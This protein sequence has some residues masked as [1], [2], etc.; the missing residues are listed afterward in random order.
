MELN[1]QSLKKSQSQQG[2][3]HLLIIFKNRFSYNVYSS[4][5][6]I[7][8]IL[9]HPVQDFT[10]AQVPEPEAGKR[11]LIFPP[12]EEMLEDHNE[13]VQRL[14]FVFQSSILS[15]RWRNNSHYAIR[16]F[17]RQDGVRF[18]HGKK[19]PFDHGQIV[20]FDHG[21]MDTGES[22]LEARRDSFDSR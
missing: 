18:D 5:V 17:Q 22:R 3:F 2:D 19:I 4:I 15:F 12:V 1:I 21:Q 11:S 7:S 16:R 10:S 20:S 8:R 14:T 9:V 6:Y 13:L